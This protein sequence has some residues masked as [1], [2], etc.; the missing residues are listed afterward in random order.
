[1]I[2]P[3]SAYNLRQTGIPP[4]GSETFRNF[5]PELGGLERTANSRRA[6]I[7]KSMNYVAEEEGFEPVV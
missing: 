1:M 3:D 7:G 2:K 4:E 6:G 5:A